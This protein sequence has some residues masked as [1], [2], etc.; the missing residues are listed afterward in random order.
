MKLYITAQRYTT[1]AGYF[2]PDML[3]GLRPIYFGTAV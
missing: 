2:I 1:Y 3:A